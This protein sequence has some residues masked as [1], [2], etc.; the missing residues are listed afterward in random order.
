MYY[1]PFF[2]NALYI[3]NALNVKMH[4]LLKMQQKNYKAIIFFFD[5]VQNYKMHNM[6]RY[7]NASKYKMHKMHNFFLNWRLGWV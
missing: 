1:E 2:L 3:E 5:Y 6:L 4:L 7:K